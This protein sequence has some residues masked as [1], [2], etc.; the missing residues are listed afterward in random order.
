MDNEYYDLLGIPRTASKEEIKKAYKEL[1]RKCHPDKGGDPDNFKKI[2]EAYGILSDENLRT[3]YDR[4]GK[5]DADPPHPFPDFF[6]NMFPFPM[7]MGNIQKRTPHRNMDLELTMEEAFHGTTIKYRYKRK[8]F[9]GDLGSASCKQCNGNGK[10]VEQVRSPFGFIQNI[11][12]CPSCTGMGISVSENQF[13][14]IS[15]IVDI[16][17]PPGACAGKQFILYGKSDEMPKMEPGDIVLTIIF[18]KHPTFELVGQCDLLWKIKIHPF[19]ALTQFSRSVQLPSQET[20]SI[21]HN[22]HHRFFS[23]LH[24]RRVLVGKGLYNQHGQRGN[25][26]L[27]FSLEDY[28]L[29]DRSIFQ[30]YNIPLPHLQSGLSLDNIPLEQDTP[31]PQQHPQHPEQTFQQHSHVQECRPS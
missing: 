16:T 29:P 13:Q 15:E 31:Q 24:Q 10:I 1:A 14:T 17:I 28:Y 20:I 23:T 19:E 21:G 25:L 9:K 5:N 4:F 18:K 27:Y 12:I 6:G 30:S 7:N 11:S 8:V 3:R 2:N 22:P 26:F